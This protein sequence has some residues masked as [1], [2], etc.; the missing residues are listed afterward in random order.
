MIWSLLAP[1]KDLNPFRTPCSVLHV[2]K[3]LFRDGVA[4]EPFGGL[5]FRTGQPGSVAP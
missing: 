4:A 3:S 1:V 5:V 2:K